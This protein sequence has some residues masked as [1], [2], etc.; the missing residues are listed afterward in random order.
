MPIFEYGQKEVEHLK[1]R[2]KKLGKAIDDLGFIER[3]VN[4]DIF[5]SL[6]SSIISQQISSKAAVTIFNR[7]TTLAGNITQ[8]SIQSLD[9]NL[10]Q[11]CGM[12]LRKAGYI[13]SAAEAD[14]DFDILP[15]LS[16]ED[17]ISRLT[18]LPGIGVWT[19]EM[20]LL[21]SLKRYDILSYSDLAIRRGI[22]NLYGIE[23]VTKADFEKYRKKYSPYGSVA[24]L[25]LWEL[26]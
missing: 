17:V 22:M 12:S 1:K 2:D 15:Q 8:N 13:K 4:D 14:I 10:I 19:A 21:F 3:E 9:I 23:K 5:T 7:L 25:Y 20:L 24:S 26:S 18:A 16:D 11:K 6:V